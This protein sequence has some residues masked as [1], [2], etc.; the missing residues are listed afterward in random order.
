[1]QVVEVIGTGYCQPPPPGCPRGIYAIMVWC[2]YVCITV[3]AY[4]PTFMSSVES[5]TFLH[6]RN[7]DYHL[8]P[9]FERILHDLMTDESFILQ[10]DMS[11][12]SS[13]RC[14]QLGEPL[15]C[16]R[17]LYTDLQSRYTGATD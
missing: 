3:I 13:D 8:R 1:M 14:C 16:G 5:N 17:E 7:P 9:T 11:E 12:D 10:M 4:Q 15:K 6:I 2:W